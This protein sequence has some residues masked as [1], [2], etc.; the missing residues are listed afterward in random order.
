[1]LPAGGSLIQTGSP[2]QGF[3]PTLTLRSM[4]CC[5]GMV[6]SWS[7]RLSLKI[8]IKR[9][10]FS[11]FLLPRFPPVSSPS[12]EHPIRKENKT[13][14]IPLKVRERVMGKINSRLKFLQMWLYSSVSSVPK[15]QRTLTVTPGSPPCLATVKFREP[16][17]SK[18][19]YKAGSNS[20]LMVWGSSSWAWVSWLL[21][22]WNIKAAHT[23]VVIINCFKCQVR[24]WQRCTSTSPCGPG[25][26]R[27]FLR[28]CRLRSSSWSPGYGKTLCSFAVAS[29]PEYIN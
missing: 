21:T 28:C 12:Q 20:N 25:Q 14:Q 10:V 18:H 13:P 22:T 15:N 17:F 4:I 9:K 7:C 11:S 2:M 6:F 19:W 16:Q 3:E 24:R 27:A 1:M 26:R 8:K 23:R 5:K 29:K